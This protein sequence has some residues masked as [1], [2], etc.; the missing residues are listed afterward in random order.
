MASL[1]RHTGSESLIYYLGDLVHRI[2]LV[3]QTVKNLPAVQETQVQSLVWED[4]VEKEMAT[5][6]S[7]LA[8]RIPQTEEHGR[9]SRVG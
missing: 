9:L 6:S 4:S 8:W 1:C 5:H 2:S 7:I 3:A